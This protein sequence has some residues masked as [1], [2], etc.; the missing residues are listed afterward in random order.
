MKTALGSV[1]IFGITF[2]LRTSKKEKFTTALGGCLTIL[3]VLLVA[4]FSIF[5]GNDF[6]YKSN[7]TL[8]S[9]ERVTKDTNMI[10]LMESDFEI[11]FR[12]ESNKFELLEL[13]QIPQGIVTEYFY[14]VKDGSGVHKSKTGATVKPK[15]CSETRAP[16][17][18]LFK[19]M[20]L[21][22]WY[23]F[24]WSALLEDARTR[25]NDPNAKLLFGGQRENPEFGC[26]LIAMH[27]AILDE[28]RNT[29]G[30]YTNK[31]V[32]DWSI[33]NT[34]AI[35]LM[36]PNASIDADSVDQ[37]LNVA[38][39]QERFLIKAEMYRR[40]TRVLK[41]L[42]LKDDQGWIFP[43]YESLSG[44]RQDSISP[45]FFVHDKEMEIFKRLYMGQFFL[46]NDETHVSRKFMKIQDLFAL[47]GGVMKLFLS[48][49]AAI[50][51]GYAMYYRTND[52]ISLLYDLDYDAKNVG[53]LVPDVEIAS[54]SEEKVNNLVKSNN[55]T[56]ARVAAKKSVSIGICAFYLQCMFRKNAEF[57]ESLKV[58]K[59]A[60][61]YLDERV[62][63]EFLLRHYERFNELTELVLTNEQ[64][65]QIG[66]NRKKN[67]SRKLL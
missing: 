28:N 12:I 16:K 67:L 21:E 20:D 52:L 5:F 66:A 7:P 2:Q 51:A 29:I 38:Y 42:N 30:R 39:K 17:N 45:E 40:E 36:Y 1:D 59:A 24:D 13:D 10:D 62:D 64:I 9:S 58:L 26:I 47:V 3:C 57:Q 8:V 14:Q 56:L 37:P 4:F 46:S 35:V 6:Y 34:P 31:E 11:L 41:R 18:P 55:E 44:I 54:V 33:K 23:C 50:S 61:E 15:R 53:D 60:Q 32:Q 65:E 22:Q 63:L 25:S 48:T 43:T 49:F 19:D 27:N